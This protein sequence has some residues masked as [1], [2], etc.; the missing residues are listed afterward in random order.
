[1]SNHINVKEPDRSREFWRHLT[2][3]EKLK[4]EISVLNKQVDSLRG[5]LL[6]IFGRIGRGDPVELH[7]DDGRIFD[8]TGKLRK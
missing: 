4:V 1:M 8:L 3:T 7:F 2:E 6:A 5:D